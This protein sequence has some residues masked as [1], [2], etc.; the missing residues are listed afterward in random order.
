MTYSFTEKKRIRKSFAKRAAVLDVPFLLATQINSYAEFLQ[1]EVARATSAARSGLQSAF[2]SVFPIS[3][4]SGNARLEFVSY[5]LGEPPFDVVECQQRGLT[6]AS[7]LRAKVR[8]IDH[9]PRGDQAHGQGGEGAGGLH[10]RDPAHDPQR[11]L[12]HQRHRARDRL[13]AAPLARAC[14]SSTTAARPTPRASSSS[15]RA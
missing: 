8:L 4:H 5:A 15:R 1:A 14:S 6:F 10:G 12:R 2:Q 7:P 11:L 13:A 3:S 9:G